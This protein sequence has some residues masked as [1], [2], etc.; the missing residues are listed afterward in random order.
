VK[1]RR[2]SVNEKKDEFLRTLD[3]AKSVAEEMASK[4]RELVEQGQF[5]ADLAVCNE[6]FVRHFPDDSFLSPGQW[7]GQIAA[8]NGLSERAAVVVTTLGGSSQ[9]LSAV[10]GSTTI[11]TSTVIS[12]AYIPRMPTSS[13]S[14]A[15][16]AYERYEELVERSNLVDEIG[17][18][19]HRLGLSSSILGYESA[20][21]LLL[22][23]KQ[24]FQVPSLEEVSPS[25]VLIP[26]RGAIDR[27]LADLLPKR[28]QQEKAKSLQDKVTSIATQC[29][30]P[31]VDTRQIEQLAQE[32]Y[33]LNDELSEAKQCSMSRERVREL[34]NRGFLFLRS[35]LRALDETKLQH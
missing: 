35:F 31:S 8:W 15:R 29:R 24:A 27:A 17:T 21:S 11:A 34:M 22:Q 20:L 5:A 16:N 9:W 1:V 33:D 3:K 7:D 4:G 26:L 28:P 12:S 13:Q 30:R 23:S 25:A 32:A 6:E 2:T 14:A 10:V 18:E 19:I